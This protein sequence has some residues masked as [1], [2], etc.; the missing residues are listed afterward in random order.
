MPG[1]CTLAVISVNLAEFNRHRSR[2]LIEEIG[3]AFQVYKGLVATFY[4]YHIAHTPQY[5]GESVSNWTL[6]PEEPRYSQGTGQKEVFKAQGRGKN[7]P[8]TQAEPAGGDGRPNLSAI[9]IAE[10]S[11][12]AGL[13][14]ARPIVRGTSTG[15]D[16]AFPG[17][18][19]T[20]ATPFSGYPVTAL[21][22]NTPAGW[23]RAVNMPGDVT[24]YAHKHLASLFSGPLD[25]E[26]VG[27]L[28]RRS[29]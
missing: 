1:R 5:T 13:A 7:K 14:A 29:V 15:W 19:M 11:K 27:T 2:W 3:K 9:A 4:D 12:R 21:F 24:E 23:L 25:D 17:F 28:L 20:N 16:I 6:S 8:Y 22:E 26:R 10:A 18:F